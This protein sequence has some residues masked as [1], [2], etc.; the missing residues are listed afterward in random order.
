ML[1]AVPLIQIVPQRWETFCRRFLL[2]S[3]QRKACVTWRIAKNLAALDF[4]ISF[5][6]DKALR[7]FP[8]RIAL[9][10]R[11]CRRNKS[12]RNFFQFRFFQDS[13]FLVTVPNH[14]LTS[15]LCFLNTEREITHCPTRIKGI[16][17]PVLPTW[18]ST[19]PRP[20]IRFYSFPPKID[21]PLRCRGSPGCSMWRCS[22][23]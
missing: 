11:H 14:A 7:L 21:E 6:S 15:L 8:S 3:C 23:R 4:R 10:T 9:N 1:S 20:L 16:P 19:V 18:D 22:V 5:W 13:R 2:S 12:F 17:Y